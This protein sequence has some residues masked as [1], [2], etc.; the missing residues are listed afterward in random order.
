METCW[1]G[2]SGVDRQ[3]DARPQWRHGRQAQIYLMVYTAGW[4]GLRCWQIDEA[5]DGPPETER[6]DSTVI[7]SS[8]ALDLASPLGAPSDAI[9]GRVRDVKRPPFGC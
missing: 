6:V 3:T 7:F 5:G 4:C 8:S 1:G 2:S 9:T